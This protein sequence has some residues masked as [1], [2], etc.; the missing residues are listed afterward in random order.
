MTR[1][2]PVL[3]RRSRPAMGSLAEAMLIG[4]DERQLAAAAEAALDEIERLSHRWSRFSTSSEIARINRDAPRGWVLVDR[5]L[6][7]V[8]AECDRWRRL[9]DGA[10][11]ITAGSWQ[12]VDGPQFNGADVEL[13]AA[14]CAI[15]FRVEALRLDLGAY[16][17]GAALDL[18]GAIFLELGLDN[19]LLQIG[20][21][22]ILT[23][24]AGPSGDGWPVKLRHPDRPEVI[25]REL[26]LHDQALSCS[27][28]TAPGATE[29][30]VID[31][32]TGL[33]LGEQRACC[34]IAASAA[35][36]DA[37][38]TACIVTGLKGFPPAMT[39]DACD[40]AI[41]DWL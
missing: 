22:S 40:S 25:V 34:V 3:V 13:D 12:I 32:R 6:F 36:A 10:F 14:R 17:K 16:G 35:A 31:P 9:S 37:L 15:R 20:T 27:A 29:S 8:L 7:E 11:D 41:V 28:A 39:Q 21:S 2:E 33:P 19:W 30:D 4:D 1:I 24:G 23:C 18:A 38:S 5:E 26:L